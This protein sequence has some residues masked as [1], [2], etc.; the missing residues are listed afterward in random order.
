[1]QTHDGEWQDVNDQRAA[2]C[3]RV[4]EAQAASGACCTA[5]YLI[6]AALRSPVSC[7]EW[8]PAGEKRAAKYFS[9]PPGI[10]IAD[11]DARLGHQLMVGQGAV[12]QLEGLRQ[13]QLRVIGLTLPN[14]HAATRK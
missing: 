8:Q 11:Q 2:D 10:S 3:E 12:R 5:L 9:S 7:C 4:L 6:E 1:M 14:Q 13:A